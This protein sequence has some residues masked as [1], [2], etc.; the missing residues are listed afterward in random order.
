MRCVFRA[1][2]IVHTAYPIIAHSEKNNSIFYFDCVVSCSC[3]FFS[4]IPCLNATRHL[5]VAQQYENMRDSC[6]LYTEKKWR[7]SVKRV[8]RNDWSEERIGRR[9]EDPKRVI[10]ESSLVVNYIMLILYSHRDHSNNTSIIIIIIAVSCF[11]FF[12]YF[13]AIIIAY[14]YVFFFWIFFWFL[15]S[16]LIKY[17]AAKAAI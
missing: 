8:I 3:T 11:V 10:S 6:T 17:R 13:P 2:C 15:Y 12:L 4:H 5:L 1:L 16:K 9:R 7:L 14:V